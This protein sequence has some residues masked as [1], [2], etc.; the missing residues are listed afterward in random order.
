MLAFVTSPSHLNAVANTCSV[1]KDLAATNY[2]YP[3]TVTPTDLNYAWR[4][5][6]G[7][8]PYCGG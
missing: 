7:L 8:A 4:Q 3:D 6:G 1:S 2:P 5:L